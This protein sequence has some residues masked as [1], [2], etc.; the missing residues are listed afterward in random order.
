M[1]QRADGQHASR[2]TGA[3]MAL[4]MAIGMALGFAIGLALDNIA[5]G[6][7]IGAG[8]GISFGVAFS[9]QRQE[10][11]KPLTIAGV[12]LVLFGIVVLAIM[13]HLIE[14][15]WWCQYPIL[16]LIPGC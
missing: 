14:P 1:N 11:S 5:I 2:D 4:G 10:P 15:Q 13:M 9:G 3:K 16:N 7:A 12:F 6:V 8:L